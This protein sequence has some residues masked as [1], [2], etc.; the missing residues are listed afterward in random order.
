MTTT[1]LT[2]KRSRGMSAIQRRDLRDGLLF[3]SPFILGVLILW[4]GPM[5]YSLFLIT[6]DW[7]LI[8][9]PRFIGLGNF[10]RLFDDPL[11]S[12]SLSVT[13]YFTFVGVPLQLLTAFGLALMLNQP[14]RGQ[15]LYRT[16]YY[17]PAITPAVASAVVWVQILNPEF[18]VLNSLLGIFGVAPIKWLFD[19]KAV[20]PAFILMSLW[21]V[22]P[23]MIIFLAGL[24]GVPKE[25]I[26]AA[27][28]DGANSWQRF[29][30]VTVPMVSPIIFF[31]LVV[32]IIGSF[33][34]FTSSFVMTRGG[35]QDSTR[36][37]ALY[38]YQNAFEYFRMGYAAL[39]SWVI[40]VIVMIFTVIQF[41]L[42]NNW[43][44]YGER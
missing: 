43:V 16:I 34:V 8:R 22:G 9:A 36:F 19:P 2:R 40:F 3:S 35:P 37:M 14:I 30:K 39:L 1:T 38:I 29:W 23:Q 26:E 25:L 28:I 12:K 44:Y 15:G 32:G 24:Q 21:F 7:N 5:L 11:V 10:E 42:A 20:I 41:R 18:G 4:I 6:Q 33:Q 31:N 13:A 27:E 17:L